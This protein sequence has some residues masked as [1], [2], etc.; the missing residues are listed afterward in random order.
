MPSFAS[1]SALDRRIKT[2]VLNGA[3]QL[4]CPTPLQKYNFMCAE[5]KW[6][7]RLFDPL[8][9]KVTKPAS[10]DDQHQQQQQQQQQQLTGGTKKL[11]TKLGLAVVKSP[12][13]V[14]GRLCSYRLVQHTHT[15]R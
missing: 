10:V 13:L 14:S 9:K 12:G 8:R 4:L 5:K 15:G 2:E 3:F 11:P 6:K 1:N 7:K